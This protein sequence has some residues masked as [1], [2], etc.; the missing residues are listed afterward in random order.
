MKNPWLTLIKER[1]PLVSYA[2]LSAGM[3]LSSAVLS[4]TL[5][6]VG[7]GLACFGV[8]LFFC[9]LRL[10]D[11]VKDFRKDVVAH[12]DRPLPRG[13]LQPAQVARVAHIGVLVM[14]LYG[15]ALGASAGLPA[16]WIYLLI[17]AYLWLMY[18]EFFLGEWL[19]RRPLLYA[20][21]HQ[22]IVL[23]LCALG[24]LSSGAAVAVGAL[25]APV[26]A[27][28][29]AVLGAFFSYEVCRKLDPA[30]HPVLETYLSVYGKRGI[31]LIVAVATLVAALGARGFGMHAWLWPLE[32]LVVLS[33]GILFVKP[34]RFK[35]AEG[36][37]TLSLVIHIWA[38]VLGS[39]LAAAGAP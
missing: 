25:P 26:V 30:A 2:I 11:E 36:L 10:M 12:P 15:F 8:L 32:A 4:G 31:V 34:E 22:V 38:G 27:Y 5:E 37:A 7:A 17:T 28:A 39:V 23:P 19:S 9:E 33:L 3:V 1:I 35:L 21:T 24:A 6:P 16:A 14:M 20:L 18:R 13:V 29:L